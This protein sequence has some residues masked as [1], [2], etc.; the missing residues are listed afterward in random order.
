M[1]GD[2]L[3]ERARHRG[4]KTLSP[5][6]QA[7]LW[8]A[9]VRKRAR[10]TFSILTLRI[11]SGFYFKN[12][13]DRRRNVKFLAVARQVRNKKVTSKRPFISVQIPTYNRSKVLVERTVPSILRQTYQN[14]EIIIVG[15]HCTDDTAERLCEF[16]SD[17]IRFINLPERGTY[18]DKPHYRWM[19]AGTV[20]ANKAIDLCSGEWIAPLD[21]DD[22]FSE[23]HLEI[24]LDYA[25]KHGFEMVYGKVNSEVLPGRWE[26][27]GSYPPALGSISRMASLYRSEL[28]FFK[29][30][31]KSWKYR[32]PG[33][34]NMWRRMKE[35]GVKIGFLDKVVGNHYLERTQQ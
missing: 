31:I 32:E 1:E 3:E 2:K 7:R 11:W 23:D 17:R 24:L 18:P 9:Q 28:N 20:P 16:G 15:D 22:E 10:L 33:D 27:L 13:V 5:E 4:L 30:D 26:E 14:F 34:W 25:V 35:A 19:V 21:D 6:N 8:L 12:W 29:Y